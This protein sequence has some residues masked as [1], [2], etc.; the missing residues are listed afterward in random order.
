MPGAYR[1][2]VEGLEPGFSVRSLRAGS[3]DLLEQPF[4]VPVDRPAERIELE[5]DYAEPE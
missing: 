3:V 2:T 1:L 5:L 4:V